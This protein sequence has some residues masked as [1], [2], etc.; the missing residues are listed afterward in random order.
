MDSHPE[1]IAQG[2]KSLAD[3][4]KVAAAREAIR[5]LLLGERIFP[6]PNDDHTG[7]VGE[8]HFVTLG[9]HALDI[10]G[11]KRKTRLVSSEPQQNQSNGGSGG[12]I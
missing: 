10:A 7:V 2:I 1:L 5:K 6:K 9:D 12:R 3:P 11:I 8:V 4:V